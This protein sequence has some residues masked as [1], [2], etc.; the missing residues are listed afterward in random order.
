MTS[1]STQDSTMRS[2]N[3][4]NWVERTIVYGI[5]D[6][7]IRFLLGHLRAHIAVCGKA[8]GADDGEREMVPHAGGSLRGKEIAAGRLEEREG[9]LVLEGGRV[10]QVDD[11]LSARKRLGQSL[12]GDGVDARVR[13][14]RHHLIVLL[15]KPA[16]ELRADETAASDDLKSG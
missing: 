7:L 10:C 2:M 14:R 3:S 13:G 8:V 15:A 5:P 16:H 12:A 4:R 1:P 9:R 11:N 6:A